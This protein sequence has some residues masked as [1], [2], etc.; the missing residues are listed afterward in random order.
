MK[1]IIVLVA[2]LAVA[3]VACLIGSRLSSDALGMAL[4]MLLGVLSGI[5]TALLVLV[6]GHHARYEQAAP[7]PPPSY[8][9]YLP[10]PPSPMLT[11]NAAAGAWRELAAREVVQP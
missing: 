2:I 6:A 9:V 7:A 3:G 8:V 10:S 1:L 11:D 5:P 4:G